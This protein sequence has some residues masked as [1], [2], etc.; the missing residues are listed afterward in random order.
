M[1]QTAPNSK[2]IVYCQA[3]AAPRTPSRLGSPTLPVV[4]TVVS[5]SFPVHTGLTDTHTK[6]HRVRVLRLWT[7]PG[8]HIEGRVHPLEASCNCKKK[9]F[10]F[11]S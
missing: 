7:V 11:L 6:G 9:F 3:P 2:E 1:G 4:A 8:C 5:A 10:V